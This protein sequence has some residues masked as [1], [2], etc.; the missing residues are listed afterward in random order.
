MYV[1]LSRVAADTASA[2]S[3]FFL[4]W[5]TSVNHTKWRINFIHTFRSIHITTMCVHSIYIIVKRWLKKSVQCLFLVYEHPNIKY[6]EH[7]HNSHVWIFLYVQS[8]D[9]TLHSNISIQ[10][11][12][13]KEEPV[14]V[15]VCNL[16]VLKQASG[17]H[18]GC[19]QTRMLPLKG[20][21]NW[22]LIDTHAHTHMIN[23]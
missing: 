3:P 20:R 18:A 9:S 19:C 23:T 7:T 10:K 1:C 21:K 22:K 15:C 11:L 13:P 4:V 17:H 14:S 16:T 5:W 2:S 12:K 6:M 8:N